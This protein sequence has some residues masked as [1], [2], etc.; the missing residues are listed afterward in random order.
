MSYCR[1][2]LSVEDFPRAASM[3]QIR[4][5]DYASHFA[6]SQ[7]RLTLIGISFSSEKRTIVEEL[8]EEA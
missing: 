7:K 6:S 1:V 8:V 3:A 5:K 4:G 2:E